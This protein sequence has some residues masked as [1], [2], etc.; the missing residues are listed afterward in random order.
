[1]KILINFLIV[2]SAIFL[3][4]CEKDFSENNLEEANKPTTGTTKMVS[5]D[6]VPY[7]NSGINNFKS[8]MTSKGI[9]DYVLDLDHIIEFL[10]SNGYK[11]YSIAIIENFGNTEDYYF[12]NLNLILIDGDWKPL[13][14]KYNPED[15]AKK[16]N[17]SV[18]T[19]RIELFDIDKEGGNIIYFENGN[20]KADPAPPP[21]TEGGG[22]GGSDP[23]SWMPTWL[24]EA[25]GYWNGNPT[26]GPGSLSTIFHAVA[27]AI[28]ESCNC[29]NNTPY[30]IVVTPINLGTYTSNNDPEET[31]N[32]PGVIIAP[33]IPQWP[34][35]V[36]NDHMRRMMISQR[37]TG[38]T[39]SARSWLTTSTTPDQTKNLY[40]YLIEYDYNEQIPNNFAISLINQMQQTPT[41]VL[42]GEA[43]F[44]SPCNIDLT[45]VTPNPENTA[46]LFH[47]EKEKFICVYNKLTQSSE[48]KSLFTDLFENDARLNVT[49]EIQNLEG[50]RRG[51]THTMSN[52]PFNNTIIIDSDL[53]QNGNVMQIVKTIIHECIHAYLNVKLCDPSIGVSISNLNNMELY[54][55]IN[56]YY[57]NFNN[58]QNQHEF[59]YNNMIP[60]MQT[61]LSQIKNS[62]IS[63]ENNTVMENLTLNLPTNSSTPWNWDD[64][65]RNL[66]LTGL[67]NCSFFQSEIGTLGSNPTILDPLK[68]SFYNQ[69]NSFGNSYLQKTCN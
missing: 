56:Q 46:E 69:Y 6:D 26:N 51:E 65:Y 37:L 36:S 21:P 23:P 9:E 34:A 7:L 33:N 31:S 30:V 20:K 48:F 49:F 18:Y 27:N 22:G 28:G 10:D 68:W 5:I 19:G 14:S 41:L 32:G 44:N 62:L 61:I 43:S 38:L 67:E 17:F 54:S 60:V 50:S 13:I 8:R 66:S 3:I 53:L 40:S 2:F 59:I 1:M 45:K 47:Q 55:C 64:F 24:A 29:N 39:T 35:Y 15:D 4:S 52:N 12:K 42:N 57:N 11:S 58:D 16:I 25:L 63:S